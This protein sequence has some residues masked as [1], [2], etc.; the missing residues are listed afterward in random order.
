MINV[1][2]SP[3]DPI[4]FLHHA[5]IDRVW[6]QWQQA[7]LSSRLTDISGRNV[8]TDEALA[9]GNL[10]YPTAAILDYDGD[11]GNVTTLNHTLW[12]V[13]LIA[14]ATAGDVMDLGGPVSCAEYV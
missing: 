14:N 9:L 5:Y 6:W 1:A 8:P 11:P 4:F 3:G 12:M 10:S 2:T 7:N 13:D